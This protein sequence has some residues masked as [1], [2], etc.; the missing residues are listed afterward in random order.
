[1]GVLGKKLRGLEGGRVAFM[2]PG[3]SQM[4]Q[5]AVRADGQNVSGAWGFNHNPD[6]PT[7]S[8][9]VL[10]TGPA[11]WMTDDEH[12]RAMQGERIDLPQMRCHS[13]VRDG[14]IEFLGDCTHSL[15][16]RTVE[17]PDLEEG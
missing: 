17:L 9:S 13:F 4:H 8:P 10:V 6:A 12:A 2:C 1:M 11:R 14:R 3:C 15:A 16:S 7:L 5:V